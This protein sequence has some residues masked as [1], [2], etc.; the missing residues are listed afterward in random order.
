MRHW[1][2]EDWRFLILLAVGLWLFARLV[3]APAEDAKFRHCMADGSTHQEC[4]EFFK[5]EDAYYEGTPQQ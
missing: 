2:W 5:S 4:V 3:I 1:I